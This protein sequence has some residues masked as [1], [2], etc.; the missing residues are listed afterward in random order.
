VCE[1]CG[2]VV[3]EKH[4]E[5]CT[6][7]EEERRKAAEREKERIRKKQEAAERKRQKKIQGFQDIPLQ[8]SNS[9]KRYFD[10]YVQ[11]NLDALDESWKKSLVKAQVAIAQDDKTKARTTLQKL[12]REYPDNVWV[13]VNLVLSYKGWTHN[14]MLQAVHAVEMAPRMASAHVALGHANQIHGPFWGR[15]AVNHYEKA[16]EL[17]EDDEVALKANAHFQIGKIMYEHDHLQD[18][19]YRWRMALKLDP[20]FEPAHEALYQLGSPIRRVRKAKR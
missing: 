15:I 12:D 18:A 3:C 8:L 17:A 19:A 2:D 4:V 9:M 6:C 20:S 1:N 11:E 13:K 7:K 5:S 14:M 16:L 10:R